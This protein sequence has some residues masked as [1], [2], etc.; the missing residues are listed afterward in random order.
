MTE[1]EALLEIAKAISEL[2]DTMYGI[3]FILFLFLLFKKM[4]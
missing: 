4:G 3:G 1:A 2:A